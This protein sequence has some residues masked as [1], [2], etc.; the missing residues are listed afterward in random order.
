VAAEFDDHVADESGVG[1]ADYEALTQVC[2]VSANI[3]SVS[4]SVEAYGRAGFTPDAALLISR[5]W[6]QRADADV[7]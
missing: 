5:D 2:H 4:I 6:T 7:G 3:K 1:A